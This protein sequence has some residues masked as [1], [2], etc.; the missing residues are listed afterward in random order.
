MDPSRLLLGRLG[1]KVQNLRA[2]EQSQTIQQCKTS[3]SIVAP[4]LRL[5]SK[6]C[7]R[8]ENRRSVIVTMVRIPQ[9]TL[10]LWERP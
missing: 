2:W 1:A 10:P 7:R 8:L 6:P 9:V 3:I 4:P 5:R